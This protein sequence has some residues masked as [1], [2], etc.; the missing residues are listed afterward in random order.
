M[1]ADLKHIKDWIDKADHDLGSA[2]IIFIHIPE[3]FDTIAFHCQQAVEKYI[4]SA[5]IF[6]EIEFLRSHDLIYLLDLLSQKNDIDENTF[7]MAIK[8]NG[9]SVQI[10][11]PNKIIFLSKEEL[12]YAIN[13]AEYFRTYALQITGINDNAAN[14]LQP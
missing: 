14:N 13:I 8:L 9:F 6:Y 12:E 2:K 7:N 1:S 3:Y 4:K 10:R 11:Y 5:L